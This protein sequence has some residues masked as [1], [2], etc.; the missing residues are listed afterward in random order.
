MFNLKDNC[1]VF[2]E[3][4]LSKHVEHWYVLPISLVR[5]DYLF[6]GADCWKQTYLKV[7][8]AWDK[9]P[10]I[11]VILLYGDIGHFF[12]ILGEFETQL[13]ENVKDVY[14]LGTS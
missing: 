7:D 1:H 3:N 8:Q 6:G 13:A 9:H 4:L 2:I 12:E 5:L 14:L 11:A 10:L